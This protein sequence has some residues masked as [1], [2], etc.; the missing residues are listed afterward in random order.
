[1]LRAYNL[2][3]IVIGWVFLYYGAIWLTVLIFFVGM[4]FPT[5]GYHNLTT[6]Q[7]MGLLVLF[8]LMLGLGYTLGF[9]IG[10]RST[11]CCQSLS[12]CEQEHVECER[13]LDSALSTRD[14]LSE[15]INASLHTVVD[16]V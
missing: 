14:F 12:V 7:G 4:L 9:I 13:L 8:L 10:G 3:L 15:L 2:M 5:D 16:N 11:V 1:M 6:K